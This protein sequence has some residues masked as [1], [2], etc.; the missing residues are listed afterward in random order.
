MN[1]VKTI[2]ENLNISNFEAVIKTRMKVVLNMFSWQC[3]TVFASLLRNSFNGVISTIFMQK[4]AIQN[5]LCRK[6]AIDTFIWKQ[7]S[8]QQARP[9]T[10]IV[11]TTRTN[12]APKSWACPIN[13]KR[14]T[15]NIGFQ[16]N[17]HFSIVFSWLDSDLWWLVWPILLWRPVSYYNWEEW[18]ICFL[19]WQRFNRSLNLNFQE[20]YH[21]QQL[22]YSLVR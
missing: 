13:P 21:V 17:W 19:H 6:N 5:V 20:S 7:V 10:I 14:Q 16:L 11:S 4:C 15:G 3:L 2:R 8:S 12:I 18:A 22:L 9:N 1:S